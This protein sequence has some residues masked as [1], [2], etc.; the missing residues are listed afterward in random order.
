MDVLRSL[1]PDLP[2]LV[3][4]VEAGRARPAEFR[5]PPPAGCS[6]RQDDGAAPAK[7]FLVEI[8]RPRLAEKSRSSALLREGSG[9]GRPAPGRSLVR[10][11]ARASPLPGDGH[12]SRDQRGSHAA[13]T[14]PTARHARPRSRSW[15]SRRG[16]R[17]R[18][19]EC[20][21]RIRARD[22][23]GHEARG[24]VLGGGCRT[25]ADNCFHRRLRRDKEQDQTS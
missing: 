22:A 13:P 23:G 6:R 25:G 15:G 24:R 10:R 9:D 2:A 7:T 12:E 3:A 5:G 21:Q 8:D 4:R 19:F 17:S 20:R 18:A 11:S 16:S 14:P 1:D